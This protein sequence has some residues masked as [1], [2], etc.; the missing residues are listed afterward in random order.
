VTS[1]VLIVGVAASEVE[2]MLATGAGPQLP[3]GAR[4]PAC[5]GELRG[6]WAGYERALRLERLRLVR[7]RVCRSICR[8]CGRTHALLPSFV[9]PCRLDAAPVIAAGLALAAA[10]RGHRQVAAALSLSATTVRGWLRRLR[11][12][13][14]L[15]AARLW[16]FAQ[17]LGALA[18]RPPP[19]ERPLAGLLRAAAAAH[20][21]AAARLR[22]EGL[23]D[24]FGLCLCLAGEG[25]LGAQGLALGDR[26]G[27]GEDRADR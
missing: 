17:E 16:R 6:C 11:A 2:E 13:A 21:A 25:L 10:G 22:G 27:G 15:L 18:P 23:P 26:F 19:G 1:T 20:G 8:G 12:A 9:V 4:C 5:G 7:L 3:A 14:G 24:R